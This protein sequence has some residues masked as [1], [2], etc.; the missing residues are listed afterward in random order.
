MS[1]NRYPRIAGINY[2]SM[3]DGPGVRATIYLSGCSHH[4][5]GCQNP[6]T[7]N[8]DNGLEIDQLTAIKDIA[9][10][11]K[12]RPFLSGITLSGGDPLYDPHKTLNFLVD[13]LSA[14]RADKPHA[15]NVWMYTG[16][17]W[18][19]LQ[20]MNDIDINVLLMLV[21]VL[22]DG[23]FEQDKADKR[24][25]FRGSANQRL[26]DVSKSRARR[27]VVLYKGERNKNV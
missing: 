9:T 7:W 26:I 1:D 13:L 17:T 3:V 20:A 2:E 15:I 19:E 27:K 24:L 23:R 21:N 4:C 25:R 12:K 11:I 14:C 6:D 10:E 5:L 22:V 16:Y 18:E 8:P